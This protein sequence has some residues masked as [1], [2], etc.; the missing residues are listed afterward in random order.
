MKKMATTKLLYVFLFL[1]EKHGNVR[2]KK[3]LKQQVTI[4]SEN[5]NEKNNLEER[6]IPPYSFD[7]G[8][9][10]KAAED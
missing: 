6:A 1:R 4:N 5:E 3:S 9:V 2:R 8:E 7:D 10:N